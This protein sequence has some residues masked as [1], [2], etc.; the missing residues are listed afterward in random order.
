MGHDFSASVWIFFSINDSV[1]IAQDTGY[2]REDMCR[3]A[4]WM[5]GGDRSQC[6]FH[7]FLSAGLENRLAD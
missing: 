7:D 3:A 6:I 1:E 2:G 5:D 4:G